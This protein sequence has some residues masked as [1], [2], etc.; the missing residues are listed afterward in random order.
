MQQVNFYRHLDKIVEPPFS[1]RQQLWM[2]AAAAL[3][4]VAVWLVLLV[5][6]GGLKKDLALLT[7]QKQ[8]VDAE[9][10]A[11]NRTKQQQLNNPELD[12]AISYLEGEVAFRRKL[13]ATIDPD[14]QGAAEGFA[15]HL[16]GLGRQ[17]ID[18]LW[19]TE[20]QL[21]QGGQQMVLAGNTR[22][23]EYVPRYLKKLAQEPVFQGQ[24]FRVLKMSVPEQQR[25]S[26]NFEVRS[27]PRSEQP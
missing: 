11:L 6:G 20:I 16:N 5:S 17:I 19:F 25:G 3:V 24:Q 10:E 4:M 27:R 2:V 22:Q 9:L 1:A 13:L 12:R 7:Q 8:A 15:V 18:G 14:Q 26:M 23:P 21:S